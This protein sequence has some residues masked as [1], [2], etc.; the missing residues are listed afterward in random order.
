MQTSP[1]FLWNFTSLAD[2]IINQGGTSSG[3]TYSIL[4]VLFL[5]AIKTKDLVI[6][7]CGQDIPNLKRGAIRDAKTIVNNN[8]QIAQYVASYNGTDKIFFF[9]NGSII[10]F[11]SYDDAQDAKNGKRDYLFINEANGVSYEIYHELQVR[12]RKQVFI[13]YNP[14]AAFW[15]HEKLV[16]LIDDPTSSMK[17]VRFISNYTHNK[18]LDEVTIKRIE[19]MKSDNNLWRVYGLGFTGKV[20]GLIFPKWQQVFDFPADANDVAFGLDFGFSES[21]CALV[22]CGVHDR[23]LIA[24]QLIYETELGNQELVDKIK[25]L[26]IGKAPIFADSAE[27]KSISEIRKAGINIIAVNKGGD[28]VKYSINKI[29]EYNG[30]NVIG[31][32]FLKEVSTY[33]YKNGLP[34]KQNDHLIDA[35]RYYILGTSGRISHSFKLY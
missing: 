3:K 27:P 11:T 26:N 8:M 35:L 20:K 16:P 14:N 15:V 9:T 13:D 31:L 7:V 33:A 29:N 32:D 24:K 19:A 17:V 5:L 25:A 22:K 34:I 1:V 21:K 23:N 28:S 18:F 6:T 2:V 12:T 4:Q 10:E 30:L